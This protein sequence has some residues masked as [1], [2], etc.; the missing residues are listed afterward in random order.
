MAPTK[1]LPDPSKVLP[2][3]PTGSYLHL[4]LKRFA[5]MKDLSMPYAKKTWQEFPYDA[6]VSLAPNGR[7]SC[8]QCHCKIDK[9]DLRFQLLLQCHKGCKNSAFFHSDCV[10][11]YPETKK[12]SEMSEIAGLETLPKIMKSQVEKDFAS[13]LESLP[14]AEEDGETMINRSTS[15]PKKRRKNVVV[16]SSK[17]PTSKKGKARP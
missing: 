15:K 7:A 9:N 3:D 5:K 13:F 12:I 11:K 10:W 17:S 4:K 8:R 2:L 1:G 14:D 6:A 16:D